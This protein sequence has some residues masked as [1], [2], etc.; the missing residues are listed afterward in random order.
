M[1]VGVVVFQLLVVP[2]PL[3]ENFFNVNTCRGTIQNMNEVLEHC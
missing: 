3:I 2:F 1:D